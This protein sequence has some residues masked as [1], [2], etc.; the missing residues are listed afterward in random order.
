MDQTSFIVRL[1]RDL[2]YGEGFLFV[3]IN[4]LSFGV[5]FGFTGRGA[6]V[7]ELCLSLFIMIWNKNGFLSLWCL[8]DFFYTVSSGFGNMEVLG[9][10]WEVLDVNK[11][12]CFL[13]WV[14]GWF[15]YMSVRFSW[16]E[17]GILVYLWLLKRIRGSKWKGVRWCVKNVN[18]SLWYGACFIKEVHLVY[19][20]NYG[21]H[22]LINQQLDSNP[23]FARD[24]MFIL[25]LKLYIMIMYTI[26]YTLSD[27]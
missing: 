20:M 14:M 16:Q 2:V 8:D 27:S 5:L 11:D 24:K 3:L 21:V 7:F 26:R 10:L 12:C 9:V 22:L 18:D 25:M 19:E 1:R 4:F 17:V 23:R 15:V 13:W 6:T